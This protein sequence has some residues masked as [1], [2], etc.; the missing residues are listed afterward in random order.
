MA[1]VGAGDRRA[2]RLRDGQFQQ[3]PHFGDDKVAPMVATCDLFAHGG[4]AKARLLS[5]LID[6]CV[7]NTSTQTPLR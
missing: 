1:A 2:G 5:P 6:H 4:A 7:A 3:Q